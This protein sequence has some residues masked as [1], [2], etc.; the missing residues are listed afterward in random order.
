MSHIEESVIDLIRIRAEVGK[1]KYGV[2]MDRNDLDIVEW[3]RHFQAENL[4]SAIYAE[5]AIEMLLILQGF[6][7]PDQD[8]AVGER[9]EKV[10][11]YLY[12]GIVVAA[13]KNLSG[14]WRYVVEC[15]V[16][17]TKGILHIYNAKQ[18]RAI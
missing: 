8:F 5:K 6:K 9:V 15:T 13:F 2:G 18:L 7:L 12:P 16:P 17:E 14:K 1:A 10:E 4:D 3:L 11:G